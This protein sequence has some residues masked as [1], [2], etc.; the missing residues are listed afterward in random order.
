MNNVPNI[1]KFGAARRPNIKECR[2]PRGSEGGGSILVNSLE[3]IYVCGSLHFLFR[4]SLEASLLCVSFSSSQIFPF[5]PRL[6]LPR[7]RAI[8][9]FGQGIFLRL[10]KARKIIVFE[11]SRLGPSSN[12]ITKALSLSSRDLFSQWLSAG[13]GKFCLFRPPPPPCVLTPAVELKSVFGGLLLR[14]WNPARPPEP[15]KSQSSS[16]VTQK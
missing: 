13:G 10:R 1:N 9:C 3:I 4:A 5:L 15:R 2:G 14:S 12:P 7:E 16:K 8:S 11:A 6:P